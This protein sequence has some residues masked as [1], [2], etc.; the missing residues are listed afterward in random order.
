MN[1]WLYIIALGGFLAGSFGYVTVR[2]ILWPIL[3]Y[4]RLRRQVGAAV[5][6][7]PTPDT[8]RRLSAE[9]AACYAER[10]PHWY[11]LHLEHRRGE[12]PMEAVRQLSAMA[13][14]D[15]PEHLRRQRSRVEEAL[16]LPSTE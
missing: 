14:T 12:S 5:R 10:L 9:L 13:K 6:G 3:L 4:R 7:F 1:E 16:C 15:H 11:R 8:L 2:F